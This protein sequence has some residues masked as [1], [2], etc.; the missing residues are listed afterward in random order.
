MTIALISDIH[1]NFPALTAVLNDIDSR[2]PDVIYCLGDL[3]GYNVYPNEV[4]QEIRKR[5][6][7]TIAGNHDLK[8]KLRNGSAEK[9]QIPVASG[10][11]YAYDIVGEEEKQYLLTLPH[12]LHLEFQLH[13]DKLIFL[14]VHASPRSINEYLLEDLSEE[15]ICSVMEHAN[16]DILCFGHS[17]KPYHRILTSRQEDNQMAFRHAINVGSVGKP[18]DGDPRACYVLIHI[19]KNTS[20]TK[21]KSISVEFVRCDYDIDIVARAIENSPLPN[22]LAEMLRGAY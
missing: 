8:V 15:F 1:A 6:I 14:F 2:K 12:H 11:K 9:E 22:E 18:K 19:D 7:A 5:G 4:I 3:I 16:A 13:N 17:H 21:S 10:K 20:L